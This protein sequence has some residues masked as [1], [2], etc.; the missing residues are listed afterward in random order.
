MQ[1]WTDF[2]MVAVNNTAPILRR[3]AWSISAPFRCYQRRWAQVHDV[4]FLQTHQSAD[5]VLDKYREKL[6]RKAR[7]EGKASVEELKAYCKANFTAYKVPKHIVLRESLPM[8]PVGK[9][10]RRELRDTA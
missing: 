4:R 7:E 8:T 5:K 1:R 10:L 9:I 6:E 3:T 2:D